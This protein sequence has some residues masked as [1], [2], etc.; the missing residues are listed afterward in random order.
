MSQR[1]TFPN[2]IEK[3]IIRRFMMGDLEPCDTNDVSRIFLN[4]KGIGIPHHAAMAFITDTGEI[5]VRCGLEYIWSFYV[6]KVATFIWSE[7]G[8]TRTMSASEGT[9]PSVVKLCGPL[10]LQAYR[11]SKNARS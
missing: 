6:E 10:T 3:D 11:A 1:Q 5:A 9:I 7:L 8:D 4:E 2:D